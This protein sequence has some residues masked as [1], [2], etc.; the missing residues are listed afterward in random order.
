MET[1]PTRCNG[2]MNTIIGIH[3]GERVTGSWNM[4]LGPHAGAELTTECRQF[5]CCAGNLVLRT[6]M[7][8]EE[9]VIVRNVVLRALG[10]GGK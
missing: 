2:G 6:T 4:L 10:E 5:V 3:A 9:A 7:S 1:G 8:E